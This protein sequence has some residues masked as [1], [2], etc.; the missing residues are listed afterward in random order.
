VAA[1]CGFSGVAGMRVQFH[2]LYNVLS[3]QHYYGFHAHQELE[4]SYFQ[5]HCGHVSESVLDIQGKG[6]LSRNQTHFVMSMYQLEHHKT[7]TH[8]F[9]CVEKL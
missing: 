8:F 9:F 3:F 1:F 2:V 7:A 5:D 6:P 4:A